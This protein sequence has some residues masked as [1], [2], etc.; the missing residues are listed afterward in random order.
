MR[1]ALPCFPL[2]SNGDDKKT[3]RQP[4]RRE[5]AISWVELAHISTYLPTV[6]IYILATLKVMEN[7]L[8]LHTTRMY[9]IK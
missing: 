9:A 5:A 2:L 1:G 8:E 3:A 4:A 6:L 7:F